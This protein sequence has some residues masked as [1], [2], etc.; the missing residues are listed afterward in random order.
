M[1]S[2]IAFNFFWEDIMAYELH[3]KILSANVPFIVMQRKH[4]YRTSYTAAKAYYEKNC[5]PYKAFYILEESSHYLLFNTE[6]KKFNDL[7]VH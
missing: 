1:N 7:I 3:N 6:A 4:D 5:A 2:G